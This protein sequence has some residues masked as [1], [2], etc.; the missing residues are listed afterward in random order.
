MPGTRQAR[1]PAAG[2]GVGPT[3]CSWNIGW[4]E[5]GRLS[6]VG[7]AGEGGSGP[8]GR[9]RL[10]P[11]AGC[12]SDQTPRAFVGERAA[13][14]AEKDLLLSG[15]RPRRYF[16]REGPGVFGEGDLQVEQAGVLANGAR[17][18]PCAPDASQILSRQ[19]RPNGRSTNR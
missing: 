5:P 15:C 18:V 7:A 3:F 17:F 11:G 8:G 2:T 12:R 1:S 13:L 16:S 4:G 9:S 14:A 19:D 10:F 6:G